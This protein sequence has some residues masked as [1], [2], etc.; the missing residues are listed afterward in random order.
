M[1][2]SIQFVYFPFSFANESSF[3]E[4][5]F[6]LADTRACFV[7]S[8]ASFARGTPTINLIEN[9]PTCRKT[10]LSMPEKTGGCL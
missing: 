6:C 2:L 9:R 10:G 7:G 8:S 3:T 5:Q 1:S 4:R